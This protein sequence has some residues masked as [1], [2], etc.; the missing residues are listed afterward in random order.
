MYADL[1][2]ANDKYIHNIEFRNPSRVIGQFKVLDETS[3]VIIQTLF[4]KMHSVQ[5]ILQHNCSS[6]AGTIEL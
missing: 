4:S 2:L 1:K 6:D 3:N 5:V